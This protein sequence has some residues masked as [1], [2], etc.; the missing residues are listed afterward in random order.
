MS[1]SE[2][3]NGSEDSD[4]YC[5]SESPSPRRGRVEY[6]VSRCHRQRD[7]ECWRL[8]MPVSMI[9]LRCMSF[10]LYLPVYWF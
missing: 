7:S 3:D 6:T 9:L 1:E 8:G 2:W 5:E 4:D 10:K